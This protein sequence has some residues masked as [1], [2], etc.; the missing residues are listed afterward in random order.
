MTKY[1]KTK[2]KSLCG[3]SGQRCTVLNHALRM[4]TELEKVCKKVWEFTNPKGQQ[5]LF[6][7][8]VNPNDKQDTTIVTVGFYHHSCG[9]KYVFI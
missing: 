9:P 3:R 4:E 6:A 5:Y 1:T 7:K 2:I 8:Y